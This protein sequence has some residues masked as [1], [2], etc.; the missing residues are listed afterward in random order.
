MGYND[1]M[2]K[3]YYIFRHGE[4]HATKHKRWYWHTLYS[5]TILEEGKPSVLRLAKYLK[6][7]P[8]DYNVSSP[9]LRCRQTVEL[10]NKVT[11]KKFE[12]D[13][14]I[15]E[16]TFE[17]PWTFRNRILSFILEM[18]NTKHKN[19]LICTHSAC[20]RELVAYLTKNNLTPKKEYEAPLPGV[21]TIIKDGN[22]EEI[23]FNEI[24][25]K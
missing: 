8:T 10:V 7:I 23:N 18:E 6:N 3:I 17:L 9:F 5:A 19:I 25:E 15:S 13:K 2:H 24:D 20:I 4:T 16:R 21:L 12:F 14:R 1:L 11:G 22:I